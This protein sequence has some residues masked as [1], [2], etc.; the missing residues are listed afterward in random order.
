MCVIQRE[1]ERERERERCC[2][3][4]RPTPQYR[5]EISKKDDEPVERERSITR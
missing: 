4:N 3:E 2:D 1:R 5:P